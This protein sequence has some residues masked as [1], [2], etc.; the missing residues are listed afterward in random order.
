MLSDD[1]GTMLQEPTPDPTADPAALRKALEWELSLDTR[2]LRS[3]AWYHGAI[4][5]GRAEE[6]AQENGEFLVRDCASQP[7]NYVLSCRYKSQP[8]HFVINK[9]TLHLYMISFV[10]C[11]RVKVKMTTVFITVS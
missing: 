10:R 11:P 3:H 9:V 1:E 7:G 4:P 8:L 6:I 5:R 2:D